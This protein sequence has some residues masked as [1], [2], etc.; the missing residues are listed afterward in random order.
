MLEDFINT[1]NRYAKKRFGRRVV[2][3]SFDIGTPCPWGKC[4]FCDHTAFLP[5]GTIVP[6]TEGWK[7]QFERSTAFLKKRYKTDA[8]IAYF[9][10]GTSTAGTPESLSALYRAA[11]SLPGVVGLIL[12][13]RPDY[14]SKEIIEAILRSTPNHFDIWIELGLQSTNDG[15]LLQIQRGHTVQK[16]FEAIEIIEKNGQKRISVLPH[17]ILGL[18]GET[19]E[20]MKKSV[21]ESTAPAVVEGVKLHHLQIYRNTELYHT[22]QNKPFPLFEE[23]EYITLLSEIIK[24]TDDK[25]TFMRLFSTAKSDVLIAPRW[26]SEKQQLLRKLEIYLSEHNIRQRRR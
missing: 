4:T 8:F 2:R 19:P 18:P 3:L 24:E 14:I 15:T 11:C 9:Q 21:K 25:I 23:D 13:T 16:Y 12:S 20:T 1:A 6:L 17:L 7:T 26:P 22:Y 5:P 10:S